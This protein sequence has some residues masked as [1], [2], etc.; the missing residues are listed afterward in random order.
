MT[1]A[2]AIG[3]GLMVL[4]LG[5]AMLSDL[6]SYQIP[7]S[8]PVGLVAGFAVAALLAG[9]PWELALKHLLTGVVV[10]AIGAVLHF[11]ITFG[12]GDVKL[13]AALALWFGWPLTLSLVL[14]IAVMGGLVTLTLLVFRR[15]SLSEG[16]LQS[17]WISELHRR[18]GHVP[19]AVAI[20]LGALLLLPRI[21]WLQN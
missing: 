16:L 10:F 9:L 8:V 18:G 14:A 3:G 4:L 7:N 11:T 1:L 20:G 12:A 6:T 5:W 21:T 19:Y 2:A 15:I 13:I 17:S